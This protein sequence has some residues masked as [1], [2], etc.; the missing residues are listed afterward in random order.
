MS[1]NMMPRKGSPLTTVTRH[2]EVPCDV[3]RSGGGR[4]CC[5]T[6]TE[7]VPAVRR[8]PRPIRNTAM[9]DALRAAGIEA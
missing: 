4:C 2:R 3:E 8:G 6:R 5:E 9:A 1:P 7:K